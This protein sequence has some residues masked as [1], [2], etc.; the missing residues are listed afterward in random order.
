MNAMAAAS[1]AIGDGATAVITHMIRQDSHA[2]Y[3]RWLEE[4]ATFCRASPGHLDTHVIRPISG[5]TETFT[6]VIRFDSRPHLQEWMESPTRTRLIAKVQ[7]LF[8]RGDEFRIHSGLDFWFA[9]AGSH[10]R[11]PVLWKQYLVT[12]SAIY[13]LALGVPLLVTPALR[14]IGA[15]EHV[16]LTTCVVTAVVVFLMVYVVM[17][18]YTTL[19]QRWLYARAP[20]A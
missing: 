4:I 3:E 8:V 12:W 17:P 15:P 5:L 14:R 2:A 11:V 18:R 7:P 6:V 20:V 1:D 16:L 13:P 10:A 9:P 19:L